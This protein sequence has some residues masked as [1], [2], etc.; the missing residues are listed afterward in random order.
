MTPRARLTKVE[1]CPRCHRPTLCTDEGAETPYCLMCDGDR[2]VRS[3][4][5]PTPVD[6]RVERT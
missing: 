3:D 4:R 1:T 2:H 5:L 6:R